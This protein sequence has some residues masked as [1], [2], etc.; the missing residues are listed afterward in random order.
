[1]K[2][3]IVNERGIDEIP[4]EETDQTRILIRR[5]MKQLSGPYMEF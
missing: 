3:E 1:M 2:N 4:K 5:T